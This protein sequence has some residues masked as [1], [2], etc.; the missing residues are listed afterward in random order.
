MI[1]F[2]I[3]KYSEVKVLENKAA[4][5]CCKNCRKEESES[6]PYLKAH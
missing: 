3:S 6:G 4:T 1:S 5:W 2:G